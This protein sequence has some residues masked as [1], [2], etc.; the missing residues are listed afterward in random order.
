MGYIPPQIVPRGSGPMG[1]PIFN[2]NMG[3]QQVSYASA[4][5]GPPA[6]HVAAHPLA[7]RGGGYGQVPR[8]PQ[9]TGRGR[10]V[11]VPQGPANRHK[12][13]FIGMQVYMC[14]CCCFCLIIIISSIVNGGEK[15]SNDDDYHNNDD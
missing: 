15:S 11:H 3:N 14:F 1:P 4:P 6:M 9:A 7:A 10:I 12:M 5:A 8:Q 2:N 13:F